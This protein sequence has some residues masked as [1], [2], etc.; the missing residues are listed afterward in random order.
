[1]NPYDIVLEKRE[2]CM[3]NFDE[4]FLN[5]LGWAINWRISQR[6]SGCT[7]ECLASVPDTDTLFW[8]LG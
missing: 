1:M 6:L 8:S 3:R 4:S 2:E 7:T 5:R